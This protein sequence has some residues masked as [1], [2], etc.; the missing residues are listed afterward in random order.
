MMQA[1]QLHHPRSPIMKS[2]LSLL[3]APLRQL[4]DGVLMPLRALFVV[5]L[6]GAINAATYDGVWWFKWVA[7]GM[8]IATV[9][10]LARAIKTLVV[11]GLVAWLGAKLLRRFGGG[12][13]VPNGNV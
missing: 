1:L 9:V 7:L 11:L 3:P 4:A 5:G 12:A 8:G 6:T 13:Q 2:L 10:A